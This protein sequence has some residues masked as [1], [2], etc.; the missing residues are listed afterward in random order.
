[1]RKFI[2]LTGFTLVWMML[3][4]LG[5]SSTSRAQGVP[6]LISHPG[7]RQIVR[8]D[9]RVR[10]RY[11]PPPV[12]FLAS[13]EQVVTANI[14]VNYLG[15]GWTTEAQAAFE[16]AAGIWEASISSPITIVVDAQFGPLGENILGGAGPVALYRDFDNAPQSST[17]YPVAT[18]NQLANTD[19]DPGNADIEATF[20]SN[21]PDWDFGTGSSTP[22]G[23]IS[24]VSVVLHELGHGLGFL[25]S[26][27]VDDGQGLSECTGPSGTYCYD[28]EGYPLIYDRFTENGAG[29]LL[30]SFPN[31]STALGEQLTSGEL[32][33]DSPGGNFANGGSRVPLYAPSTWAQGSSYSHLAESF[34]T[35]E[36]AL[37][38]YSIAYG[39]TIHNPGA[40][41]LCM[42][43]EMGWTVSE[44]CSEATD[45][46]INGLSA[47]NDGPT[48]LGTATQLSASILSGSN[49][50]YTWDFGDGSSG[51]GASVSHQYAAPGSYTAEVTATNPV[52]QETATTLVRVEEGISGLSA[53]NDG[54]TLLGRP[55]GFGA[56]MLGGSSVTYTWDFGDG[57]SSSGPSPSH[58]YAAPGEF[59]VQVTGSNVV[60]E[61]TAAT[62]VQVEEGISGLTATNDGP[63][64]LGKITKFSASIST[65]SQVTYSW[66]FGDGQVAS[67]V[68]AEHNFTNPGRYIV[69][70]RASNQVS[71]ETTTT[72]VDVVKEFQWIYLPLQV[73]RP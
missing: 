25:G 57:S 7:P 30:R 19:L 73:R 13:P 22:A 69:E 6:A 42:F 27:R 15:S 67:G 41:T 50:S 63:A 38:T 53:T 70:V 37:M 26:M 56:A 36:H 51:S 52:S 55:T 33:F 35:S 48:L 28:Y 16:F 43:A 46:L 44:T 40:V 12:I 59:L 72:T 21:F 23:K 32:Y 62:Q 64:L 60:S 1:M 9:P 47:G 31:N 61:M 8:L 10:Q 58:T 14:Q 34:N 2:Q 4:G 5:G 18:A 11:V 54:P 17:W 24:F 71:Q 45:I 68:E 65:G 20:S 66:D 49:V 39:E 29:I 3:I